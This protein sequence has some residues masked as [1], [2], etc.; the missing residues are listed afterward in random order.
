MTSLR[1]AK[2]RPTP[3]V[4]ILGCHHFIKPIKQNKT[5]I[6]L[7]SLEMFTTVSGL[8][9]DLTLIRAIA[10]ILSTLVTKCFVA[11]ASFDQ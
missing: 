5:T 6:C 8:K 2:G 3:S 10:N 9:N 1:G 11:L 4:T 7:I